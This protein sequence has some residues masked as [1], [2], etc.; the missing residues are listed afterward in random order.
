MCL[1]NPRNRRL[2]SLALRPQNVLLGVAFVGTLPVHF[3][4][5]G[6]IARAEWRCGTSW[7]AKV[8]KE[9]WGL[10]TSLQLISRS[11]FWGLKRPSASRDKKT[12]E[13]LGGSRAGGSNRRLGDVDVFKGM[14]TLGFQ[15]ACKDNG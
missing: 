8:L 15:T 4:D 11:C 9:R 3:L 13:R 6:G 2:T 10:L 5:S 14:I 1:A 12:T 7:G